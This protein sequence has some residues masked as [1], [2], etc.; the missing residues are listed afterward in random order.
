MEGKRIPV[1]T[2]CGM[3][4]FFAGLAAGSATTEFEAISAN[5]VMVET[6]HVLARR[7][8]PGGCAGDNLKRWKAAVT[9]R[10]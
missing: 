3:A 4:F 7:R 5:L 9:G 8:R 6:L 2:G 1:W 10:S